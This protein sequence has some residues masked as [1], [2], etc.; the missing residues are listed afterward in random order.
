MSDFLKFSQM[1]SLI[2]VKG[3]Q[4]IELK[5]GN[6]V[7]NDKYLEIKIKCI[8]TYIKCRG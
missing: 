3:M 4:K 8:K 7:L 6:Y 1:T 5:Q 2:I